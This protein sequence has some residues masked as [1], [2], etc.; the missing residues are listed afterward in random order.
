MNQSKLSSFSILHEK[1]RKQ[2]NKGTNEQNNNKTPCAA[3]EEKQ[4]NK[5]KGSEVFAANICW[6]IYSQRLKSYH[7][8]RAT[9][10]LEIARSFFS[11]YFQYVSK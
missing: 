4:V 7:V 9:D 2:T 10:K 8:F 3:S 11:T 1:K 5:N 6:K